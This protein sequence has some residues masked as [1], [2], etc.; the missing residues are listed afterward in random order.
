M[1]TG[2]LYGIGIGPGDADLIT[3]KGARLLSQARHIFLPKARMASESLAGEIAR[4]HFSPAAQLH[5]M[6]FPMTSDKAELKRRWQESA[7]QVAAV[8]KT[9]E[10]ACFITLG[11]SLLYSTYIYLV[12]ELSEILP[13]AKIV[14]IP[15]ITAFS[16]SAALAGFH[17]GEAKEPVTIIPTADDL[18]PLRQALT[19]RQTVILMKI[20]KRIGPILE[21]L[22]QTGNLENAVLC[23]RVGLPEQRVVFD[24]RA[25]K[26]ELPDGEYLAVMLIH[27]KGVQ[28]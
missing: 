13:D 15:G 24:L 3:V 7:A 20:G 1:K 8:L 2:T 11:D 9:G 14:T 5:E 19:I 10:D 21:V 22:E 18:A 12:R 16:A 4:S 25:L 6:L 26:N 28:K 27:S 17:I 23:S